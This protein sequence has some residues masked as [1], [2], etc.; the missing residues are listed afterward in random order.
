MLDRLP[1]L[2]PSSSPSLPPII[3]NTTTTTTTTAIRRHS[4][5][6][7]FVHTRTHTHTHTLS[8]VAT[9]PTNAHRHH[10]RT[11]LFFT[12]IVFFFLISFRVNN[13]SMSI[14]VTSWRRWSDTFLIVTFG[15]WSKFNP[16]VFGKKLSS[17]QILPQLVEL[18]L[19]I[20]KI[21]E[22]LSMLLKACAARCWTAVPV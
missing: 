20:E 11:S 13:L 3:S 6:H 5:S 7:R 8:V 22:K 18:V 15:I 17:R 14:R 1:L 16:K 4:L 2:P 19:E 9:R 12:W 21:Q 10:H